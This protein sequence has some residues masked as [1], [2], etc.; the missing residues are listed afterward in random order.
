ME[1]QPVSEPAPKLNL[2]Q[3]LAKVRQE[4]GYVKETGFNKAQGYKFARFGDI[5]GPIGNRLAD[6]NVAIQR[7]NMRVAEEW[8]ELPARM[9]NGDTYL[10]KWNKIR[11][12]CDLVFIDGDAPI[13]ET[14]R[15]NQRMTPS[16]YRELIQEAVGIGWDTGDKAIYKAFTGAEKYA[17][18][19]A[20]SLATGEQ[21]DPEWDSPGN[22]DETRGG[23][24]GASGTKADG[25][26]SGG[27]RRLSVKRDGEG[28]ANGRGN[29]GT[30]AASDGAPPRNEEPVTTVSTEMAA[31]IAQL[32][33][34]TGTRASAILAQMDNKRN[35]PVGTL[36]AFEEL[37]LDEGKW[38]KGVLERKVQQGA[39]AGAAN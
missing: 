34:E 12:D 14:G 26:G 36:R 35:Q 7:R 28:G 30:G 9:Q 8:M 18:R 11:V 4:F 16:G 13:E 17:Y 39:G 15:L 10:R 1:T 31:E 32:A 19:Q 29:G 3:K 24:S 6:M 21:D 37:T 2:I 33:I 20:F 5:I 23:A 38:V 25:A 22:D 27:G